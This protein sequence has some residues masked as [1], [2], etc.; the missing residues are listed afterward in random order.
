MPDVPGGNVIS[1][2]VAP[3]GE[4]GRVVVFVMQMSHDCEKV[5]IAS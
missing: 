3:L 1:T 2:V 4:P 5:V